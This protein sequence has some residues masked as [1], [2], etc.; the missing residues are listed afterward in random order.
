MDESLS[1]SKLSILG[2]LCRKGPVTATDLAKRAHIRP[3]SLT[4]LIA[5]LEKR[6]F[7]S[8]QPDEADRRRL[9][10]TITAEGKKALSADISRKEAW[11]AKVIEQVLSPDERELLFHA[12]RLLERLTRDDSR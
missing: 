6:G 10:T 7:V 12:S 1:L 8:R 11:L 9:L 5:F 3:Q 4:R 2:I